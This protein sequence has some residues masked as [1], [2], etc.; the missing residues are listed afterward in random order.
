MALRP[1]PATTPRSAGLLPFASPATSGGGLGAAPPSPFRIE[2][3]ALVISALRRA[4]SGG[5]GGGGASGAASA[6]TTPGTVSRAESLARA[7]PRSTHMDPELALLLR[8]S[9][10]RE[11]PRS[12]VASHVVSR[13]PLVAAAPHLYASSCSCPDPSFVV[14]I[15]RARVYH[16]LVL[17][18][19]V[20]LP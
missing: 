8:S 1:A 12:A 18:P 6:S 16:V 7:T 11:P 20:L 13:V 10:G 2:E 19:Q 4:V 15:H 17:F 3:R 14:L 9:A 5:G